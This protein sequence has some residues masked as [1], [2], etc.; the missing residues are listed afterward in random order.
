M[1]N[2]DYLEYI[3]SVDDDLPCLLD[4][5]DEDVLKSCTVEFD[6]FKGVSRFPRCMRLN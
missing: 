5:K 6:A 1:L 2:R 3:S 4:F